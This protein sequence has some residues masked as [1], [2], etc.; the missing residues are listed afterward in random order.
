MTRLCNKCGND[1]S[2]SQA[3]GSICGCLNKEMLLMLHGLFQAMNCSHPFALLSNILTADG[4]DTIVHSHLLGRKY[5]SQGLGGKVTAVRA[6][7]IFFFFCTT[8]VY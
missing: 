2:E 1:L 8:M 5:E 3:L 7:M 6:C 4:T